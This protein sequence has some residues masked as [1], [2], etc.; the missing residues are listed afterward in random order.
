MPTVASASA[1]DLTPLLS[2]RLLFVTGK[3]GTGKTTITAALARTAAQH[4]LRTLVCEMDA[5]GSLAEALGARIPGFD[6]V[7]VEPNLHAMVMDTEASLREYLSIHARIPFLGSFTPLA[8]VLDFVADAAPGV[9]EILAVGKVCWEVREN[10]YDIVIVD[11]EASGHI[12]SQVASPRV[13]NGLVLRGPLRDQTQWMLNILEDPAQTGVV[14]VSTPEELPVTESIALVNRLRAETRTEVAAIVVNKLVDAPLIPQDVEE[15]T[16]RH[17]ELVR[18]LGIT[19][20][21]AASIMVQRRSDAELHIRELTSEITGAPIA[22]V[23]WLV[24]EDNEDNLV[25]QVALVLSEEVL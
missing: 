6:P 10:H 7:E 9:R 21:D 16:R 12:V 11:A 25:T 5:K 23:P 4:G 13:I 8:N 2:R 20:V 3:G 14:V 15:F 18:L 17:D 24:Q 22:V 1:A 19:A